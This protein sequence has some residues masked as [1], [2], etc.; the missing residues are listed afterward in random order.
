MPSI[1][2][3]RTFPLDR[4]GEFIYVVH[5]ALPV[6]NCGLSL[7]RDRRHVDLNNA[8][9]IRSLQLAQLPLEVPLN[10]AKAVLLSPSNTVHR[11]PLRERRNKR[12]SKRESTRDF[13]LVEFQKGKLLGFFL[14]V[15]VVNVC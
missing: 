2:P 6:S 5:L 13:S 11:G 4:D 15:P 7:H 3:S 1:E 9:V 12:E 8:I 10:P 14:P